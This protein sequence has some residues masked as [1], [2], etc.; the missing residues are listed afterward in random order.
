M[1]GIMEYYQGS[2]LYIEWTNQHDWVSIVDEKI[3]TKEK[4]RKIFRIL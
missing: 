4:T 3:S 1:E 2:E